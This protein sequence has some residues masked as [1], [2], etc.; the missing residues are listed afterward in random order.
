MVSLLVAVMIRTVK[1]AILI[2]SFPF[3]QV[4]MLVDA[5]K[6]F[7][8]VSKGVQIVTTGTIIVFKYMHMKKFCRVIFTYTKLP[9]N[10]VRTCAM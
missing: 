10:Y 5:D 4:E 7:L 8:W 6:T 1:P 2:V 9:T 3:F